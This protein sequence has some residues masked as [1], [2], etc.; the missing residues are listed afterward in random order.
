MTVAL[1]SGMGFWET[2][3]VGVLGGAGAALLIL[4]LRKARSDW[5][6]RH[7]G[8]R[9]K[10]DSGWG[11]ITIPVG[12]I[13]EEEITIKPRGK[14]QLK[15]LKFFLSPTWAGAVKGDRISQDTAEIL[16]ANLRHEWH[17][18]DK[19]IDARE[20]DDRRGGIRVSLNKPVSVVATGP[21][22]ATLQIEA[23]ESLS[24]YLVVEGQFAGEAR[25]YGRKRVRVE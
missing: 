13:F 22:T 5:F 9:L 23:S 18:V 19:S 2:L 12:Q 17:G 15:E 11:A 1:A 16:D 8:F 4:G 21:P 24:A 7:F 10:P 25:R 3:G 6:L 20:K 14:G